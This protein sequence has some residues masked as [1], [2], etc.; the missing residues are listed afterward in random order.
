MDAK[1]RR[2]QFDVDL[3]RV[4]V[5]RLPFLQFGDGRFELSGGLVDQRQ[6]VCRQR[7]RGIRTESLA[8][9]RLPVVGAVSPEEPRREIRQVIPPIA[10]DVALLRRREP[11]LDLML[12]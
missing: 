1:V 3:L 8:Y 12:L 11:V 5:R 7:R 6:L 2:R 4:G 9:F 10:P